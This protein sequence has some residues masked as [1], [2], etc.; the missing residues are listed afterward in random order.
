MDGRMK[1]RW[2][3]VEGGLKWKVWSAVSVVC[4]TTITIHRPCSLP[5]PCSTSTVVSS[6]RFRVLRPPRLPPRFTKFI[7]PAKVER[8][9]LWE[10]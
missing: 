2:V 1:E 7:G 6:S 10:E 5:L 8:I 4:T 9:E 3:T